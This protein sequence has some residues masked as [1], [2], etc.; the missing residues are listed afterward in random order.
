MYQIISFIPAPLPEHFH[1][2][3]Q[4]VYTIPFA[5]WRAKD[6]NSFKMSLL[7][8]TCILSSAK[9]IKKSSVMIHNFLIETIKLS[10]KP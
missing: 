3:K 7:S 5:I 2:I 6:T 4:I 9:I 10:G 1:E 8:P